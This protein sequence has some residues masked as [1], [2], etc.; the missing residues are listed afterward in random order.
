VLGPP[1]ALRPCLTCVAS[2]SG[3]VNNYRV[4]GDI[5]DKAYAVP[6]RLGVLQTFESPSKLRV[7]DIIQR[8]MDQREMY[9]NRYKSKAAKEADYVANRKEF[10]EEA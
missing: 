6:R 9:S 5:V 1:P 2:F 3:T 8:I 4:N 7:T 10:V